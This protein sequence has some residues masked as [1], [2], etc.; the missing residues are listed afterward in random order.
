MVKH[1]LR[2]GPDPAPGPF[3][4]QWPMTELGPHCTR[5]TSGP[6]PDLPDQPDRVVPSMLVLQVY[7]IKLVL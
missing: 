1:Q 6:T 2:I 7:L 4:T 3:L 5:I